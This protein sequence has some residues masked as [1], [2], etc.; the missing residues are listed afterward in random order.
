MLFVEL[1]IT[2]LQTAGRSQ[3]VRAARIIN[4]VASEIVDARFSGICKRK[5][6]R[7][8]SDSIESAGAGSGDEWD[9]SVSVA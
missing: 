5:G 7:R 4:N 9:R 1:L 6:D 2:K 8:S 3:L